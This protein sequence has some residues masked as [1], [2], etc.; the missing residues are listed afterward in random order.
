MYFVHIHIHVRVEQHPSDAPLHWMVTPPSA[1]EAGVI[2]LPWFS[3][4]RKAR[5][6]GQSLEPDP[7]IVPIYVGHGWIDTLCALRLV[8]RVDMC[9]R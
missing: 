9:C 5:S 3:F 8:E 4:P 2:K 6:L 7:N 1:T